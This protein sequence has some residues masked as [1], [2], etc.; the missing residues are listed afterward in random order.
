M[1]SFTSHAQYRPGI[2]AEDFDTTAT[3][4]EQPTTVA[5]D[6]RTVEEVQT[7]RQLSWDEGYAAG[8]SAGSAQ[9]DRAANDLLHEISA[10]LISAREEFVAEN[11]KLAEGLAKFLLSALERAMPA[12]ST[13]YGE[14]EIAA[15]TAEILPQLPSEPTVFVQVC[16]DRVNFSHQ[17]VMN[18]GEHLLE[19]IQISASEALGGSDVVIRWQ[20][21]GAIRDLQAC[22][23]GGL[24][25][26]AP[27]GLAPVRDFQEICQKE[28]MNAE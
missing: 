14:A 10:G 22:W 21:G 25:I 16:P 11:M 26:L 28:H 15:V 6:M 24:E 17:T 8:H 12:L 20:N 27:L 7:D 1:S 3:D 4:P 9:A 19:N 18:N 23:R 13:H 2:F 5:M